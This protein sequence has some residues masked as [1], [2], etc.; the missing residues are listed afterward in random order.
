MPPIL[1]R[2]CFSGVA[3]LT[4]GWLKKR[5]PISTLIPFH[6]LVSDE[7]VPYI[8]KLYA[9]KNSR[10]FET[11]LDYLLQNF[12]PLSLQDV[13]DQLP[14]NPPLSNQPVLSR[15][16][17]DTAPGKKGFLLCF[18]DGLRQVY[19]IVAPILLRKG[20]PAALF[21]N[22]SFVDNKDIFYNLQKGWMLDQLD[23]SRGIRAAVNQACLEMAGQL[24]GSPLRSPEQLKAAIR[25]I[26]YHNRHLVT[27]L[28]NLLGIDFES[29]KNDQQPYMTLPQLKELAGKGFAIGAHSMNHPLYADISPAEQIAQTIDSVQWVSHNFALPYKTFAFPHVDT[30]V[31]NAFFH[32]LVDPPKPELDL[33]LGN[34][35]GMLEKHPRVLHR[36]IGE[37]PAIPM[38]KMAKAVLAYGLLRKTTGSQFV[39]R[40]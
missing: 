39:K 15:T 29:F 24:L 6:H 30:G 25:S 12:C 4:T 27:G 14:P 5:S 40:G 1:K 26:R 3:T 23:N 16:Q 33:I 36:F 13:I 21:I 10:Q 31:K 22:P 8:Q 19:E 2:L 38:E 11:D 34:S 20:I 9:F 32:Q 7:P 35:T 28:S 17:A 18:D 37:N